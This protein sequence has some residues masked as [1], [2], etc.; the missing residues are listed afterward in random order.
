MNA[1]VQPGRSIEELITTVSASRLNCFAGCRLKFYFR[2]V[3]GLKK[4]KSI[5]L[6]V[7]S[8][9][10]RVLQAWNWARWR[11]QPFTP[12]NVKSE[13][14]TGWLEEGEAQPIEGDDST[15]EKESARTLIDTYLRDTPI[16]PDERV[17]AIEVSVEAD[18]N[19]HGLPKLI[20]IIDLVREGRRIV[21]YK[22]T[23]TTPNPEKSL[24]LHETQLSSYSLLYRAATGL[25]E[26]AV[27]IHHLVKLKKPKIT[28]TT[29]P[30][31]TD[32]QQTRL[33]RQIESYVEGVERE[34][35]VPSPQPMSCAVCEYYHECRKWS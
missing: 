28:I 20:G 30:P 31:L 5:A 14:D 18:L 12:D 34:D 19:S 26:N 25:K 16:K 24:H 6:H 1:P 29:A 27:E 2:Y 9:V 33:F 13:L 7:G 8:V 3:L 21:D 32:S 22:T 10:H 23:A 17:E 15:E 4:S 35:F 11:K